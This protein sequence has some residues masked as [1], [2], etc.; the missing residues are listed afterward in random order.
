MSI[1]NYSNLTRIV[2]HINNPNLQTGVLMEEIPT[3][4]GRCYQGYK[5]GGVLEGAEKLRKELMGAAVWIFGIPVFNKIGTL[6]CENLLKIP[7]NIDYSNPLKGKDCVKNSIEYL[8]KGVNPENLDVSELAKY[9]DKFKGLDAQTL[10]KKTKAAKAITA[11]SA[12]ILNCI[13]MGFVIPKINQALT[14]KSME[15][16]NKNKAYDD[17]LVLSMNDYQNQTKKGNSVAFNGAIDYIVYNVENNN[18]FRLLATDGPMITGR[19]VTSRNKYEAL[20]YLMIDGGS[21]YFYNFCSKNIQSLI[22]KL[23]NTPSVNAKAVELIQNQPLSVIRQALE[24]ENPQNLFDL[25]DKELAQN[26]YKEATFGRYGKINR[27]VK[28]KEL[29]RI[30]EGILEV[31]EIIRNKAKD[32]VLDESLIKKT[33]SKVNKTNALSLAIGTIISI[34]GLAVFVPKFAYKVT[35]RLTGKNQFTG[36]AN[37]DNDKENVNKS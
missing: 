28:D 31:L 37:Y 15:K 13:A 27:F 6:I 9:G 36:I 10:I 32:N 21:I 14:K 23:T 5:R 12:V 11:I 18:T 34:L 35:E 20:E 7:M 2:T 24:A 30:D 8:T 33:L 4:I 16:R 19:M 26:I 3:D 29:A 1:N 17:S 22:S 25:F